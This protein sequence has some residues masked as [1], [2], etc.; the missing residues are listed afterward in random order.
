LIIGG[1]ISASDLIFDLHAIVRGHL[2][3]SVRGRNQ[4]L[5]SVY[6]LPNVKQVAA[7]KAFDHA[8]GTINVVFQDESTI[9]GFDHILFATG[10]RL[11]YPFLKPDPVEPT[12]RLSGFYQHIFQIGDP[13]LAIVGQVRAALTFR[14]NEYQA[15]AV[16]RYFANHESGRLPRIEDQKLWE[17]QRLEYK[18]DNYRFHEIAPD[19]ESYFNWLQEFAGRPA[20]DTNAY[21]LP[22]WDPEWEVKGF[23]IL[24][25][26]D[27]Y[28]QEITKRHKERQQLQARL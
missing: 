5:E 7:V 16:A 10:F 27:A 13:S 8:D 21:E 14:V 18:G 19:Y 2:Y 4:K 15:V 9:A 1:S 26:K 12:N 28:F 24:D 17:T 25:L 23:E 6:N 11:H 22:R 20:V 3:L